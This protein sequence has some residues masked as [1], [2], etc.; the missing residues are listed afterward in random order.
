MHSTLT[1]LGLLLVTVVALVGTRARGLLTKIAVETA[2]LL[3]I[4]MFL[5]WQGSSPLPHLESLPVDFTGAWIRALAII[6][7]LV[8]ASLVA[9]L[10]VLV[11]G[12]D[13]KSRQARLFSELIAAAVYTTSV[14]IILNSVL[15]LNVASLL[16]TSGVV[17]II[18]GLA[19]QNTL[20]D[21]F[22]GIA[23]G[24]DQPFHVGD[25]V[26]LGDSVEGVIVELNWRSIR[27]E[28]DGDDL[29]TIPNSAV[30][31]SQI[32]NRSKPTG[33]RAD[34]LEVVTTSDVAPG[35]VFELMRQATLLCPSV[36]SAPNPS[37]TIRQSGLESSTYAVSFPIALFCR[38]PKA[39]FVVRRGGS[40]DMQVSAVQRE[41]RIS[42]CLGHSYCL[43]RCRRRN[44]RRRPRR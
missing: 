6:W 44:W 14:F 39:L 9:N 40:S 26:S 8:G 37:I 7:W 5:L 12:R 35:T 2:L 21:V 28:T 19:L 16:A 30:A 32:V 42:S 13:P 41:C 34:T 38:R 33:R 18:L 17:A 29:A 23:V 15:D 3:T 27:I 31:R 24:L 22:A 4:G 1:P 43:R 20:A 36:L 25:R 11:R 10:S